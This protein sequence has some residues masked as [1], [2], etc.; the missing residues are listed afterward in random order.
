MS[1]KT[2]SCRSTE[3]GGA[4]EVMFEHVAMGDLERRAFWLAAVSKRVVSREVAELLQ[5]YSCE[6]MMQAHSRKRAL[7][8]PD[9]VSA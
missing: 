1:H 6:M 3:P 2:A 5:G 4:D 9:H 7:P 8:A